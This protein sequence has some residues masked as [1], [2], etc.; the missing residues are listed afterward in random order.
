MQRETPV[1]GKSSRV[2]VGLEDRSHASGQGVQ[3]M[4]YSVLL[5]YPGNSYYAGRGHLLK[6]SFKTP[7]LMLSGGKL[8]NRSV[9]LL[10]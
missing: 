3:V 10:P 4:E 8:S 9:P 5:S 7:A 6:V 1:H 2:P